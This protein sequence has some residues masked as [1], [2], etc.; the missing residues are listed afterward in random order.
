MAKFSVSPDDLA[1]ASRDVR[2]SADRLDDHVRA[3][4]ARVEALLS[5]GWRGQ[6]ADAFRKDWQEWLDGAHNVIGG[7][8]TTST[9]L[10]HNGR[11][12]AERES[13]NAQELGRAGGPLNI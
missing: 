9:L 6:A 10:A 4:S 3:L 5:G 8:D 13:A 12:Y 2:E 1:G 7:L 11:S